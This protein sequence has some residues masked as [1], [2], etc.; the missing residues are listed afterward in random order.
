[1]APLTFFEKQKQLRALGQA[2]LT[3]TDNV[4]SVEDAIMT[5][6]GALEPSALQNKV[7]HRSLQPR[8]LQI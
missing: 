4:R 8:R 5:D 1:M 3:D 7:S 2:P 6:A